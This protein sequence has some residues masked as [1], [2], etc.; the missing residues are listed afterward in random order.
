MA[1]ILLDIFYS[2]EN[3]NTQ[4]SWKIKVHSIVLP[5][6][7]YIISILL[8]SFSISFLSVYSILTG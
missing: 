3:R 1:Y 4:L 6:K 8:I 2:M 7:V 5:V